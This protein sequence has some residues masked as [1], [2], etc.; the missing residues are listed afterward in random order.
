MTFYLPLLQP[1]FK[2]IEIGETLTS[3]WSGCGSIVECR[4]DNVPCVIKAI[5]IP[6]HINHPKI[7]QSKFALKRKQQS[8]HV[9]YHFYKLYSHHLPKT[10][11]SIACVSAINCGD[12]YALVFKN[13]T[14]FGF[15]QASSLH[16]KPILKWLA[17]FHAFNLNKQHDELWGQ[18]CYW[19][20]NTRPDE[21]NALMSNTNNEF[22]I[23]VVAKK[24]A[25]QL[26]HAKY[27]TLIHG[28][29]KLANFA[30]NLNNEIRG[31]D[32][33]YTGAGVGIVDVMYFMTSCFSCEELYAH[34]EN[35]LAYYF[36]E[37]EH[38]LALHQPDIAVHAVTNEWKALWSAAWA[39]FYRFLAGWSPEHYKINSYMHEQ[40]VRWFKTNN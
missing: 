22:D 10:A 13:F 3:L 9:E 27:K 34:A 25:Y 32:F 12:E 40:V 39:D 8:Y 29:A 17:H 14:Q 37:L 18:G 31:Y 26:K 36:D 15:T 28:D 2:H 1:H 19:H 24:L 21:F 6:N 5:K 11:K 4:L 35:E 33:Q 20:L 30:V 38:A 23:K 7:K 16:I